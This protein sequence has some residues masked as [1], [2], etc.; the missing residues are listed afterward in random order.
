MGG[1]SDTREAKPHSA[2]HAMLWII[3]GIC[4]GATDIFST[5]YET[6]IF[7]LHD[8]LFVLWLLSLENEQMIEMVANFSDHVLF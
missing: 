6:L 5:G 8:N 4:E 1:R 7:T 2:W 3:S